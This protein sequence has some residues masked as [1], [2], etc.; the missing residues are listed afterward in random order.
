MVALKTR[1]KHFPFWLSLLPA[2]ML[3]LFSMLLAAAPDAPQEPKKVVY[4]A[5]I[6][7]I[8]DLG[9][10]PYIERVIQDATQAGAAAVVLDINTFGG[11]VDA[12]VQIRDALLNSKVPTVAFI[13]KRAISAGAL[14]SLAAEK[15][16]MGTGGTIGAA[17][18]VQAGQPGAA[19][20]PVGEKTVSYVRKEFRATAEARKRPLSIAEAMVDADVVIAG[21]TTKGKLLTLT[22]EESLR[23]KVADYR[24][25]TLED[26]LK[27]LNLEGAEIRQTT[28]NWAE[29]VLRFL[30]HPV[31]S[32]LLITIAM[33]GIL[34]ELRTPGFGFPG[35]IGMSSLGLFLW[36]HWI[37]QLAG[38]EE[39]LIAAI[40]VALLVIDLIFVAGFG[41]AGFAGILAIFTGLVMSM[42][43]PGDTPQF[44]I[45]TTGQVVFSILLAL[46]AS[47]ALMR[48]LPRTPIGR[49]LVLETSLEAGQGFESS[50][51]SDHALIGKAGK[52]TTSLHPT[53]IAQIEGQRIDVVS[54]GELIDAG[55]S[56]SVVR[57]D[58]NRVV[59][60]RIESLE[61]GL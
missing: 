13:N 49:R 18:P 33:V 24:A 39:L 37:V 19:A 6:E 27:V 21:V 43:G 41:L 35:A 28:I 57:V 34:I 46:G 55:E 30:T 58:G 15:I 2:S 54:E 36:G 3:L 11:R 59:V 16:V 53:G 40:G 23:L 51:A 52:A 45:Q 60:R 9:L 7:G 10:A 8:I 26:L 14:I 32:S 48:F 22:T 31:V 5:Q 17:T 61:K 47:L 38:W 4:V 12:A 25:D 44:I 56:I 50:P 42:V 1:F 20:Q 29:N